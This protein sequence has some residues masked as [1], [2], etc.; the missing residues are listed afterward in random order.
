MPY[1]YVAGMIPL[2]LRFYIALWVLQGVDASPAKAP[3]P[4]ATH[5]FDSAVNEHFAG[6]GNDLRV[7]PVLARP[8]M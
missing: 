8:K 6:F 1:Q 7:D 2:W 3:A 5:T 4:A